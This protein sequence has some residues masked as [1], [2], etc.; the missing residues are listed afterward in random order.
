MINPDMLPLLMF[1]ALAVLLFSG[2]P[3]AFILAGTAFIFGLIGWAFDY[4]SLIQFYNI[5][6][7]IYGAI[8]ANLILVAIPMF[9]F[10]GIMLEK[11][12]V[13]EDLLHTMQVLLRRVPGGLAMAVTA[14]GTILAATTGI[15]GASVIMMALL[16]LP[17]MLQR[18][19]DVRLATGTVAASG[20]LGILIPPSIMLI[21]L[22]NL[23]ATPVGTLFAAALIPGLLL[24]SFYLAYIY[25]ACRITP[26]L[27]PSLGEEAAPTSGRELTILLLRSFI[28]PTFLIFMVLGSILFGWAT[29]TEASGTGALGAIL[30]AVFNRRLSWPVLKE[31]LH[32]AAETNVMIFGIF[33]GATAFA[34][35][36]RALG[37]DFIVTDLFE[38]LN[39]GP[40]GV[41]LIMMVVIFLLGF[42]LDWIEII[43][44]V[45][46]IFTPIVV[47]LDFGGHVQASQI[48]PWFAILIAVN[49]QTSYLT[50]PFGY[51]L[52]YMKGAS[53]S[54]VRMQ[55]IYRGIIPFVVLQ[56]LAVLAVAFFPAVALWLPG[57]L[58]H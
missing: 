29:P 45:L 38:S 9:I 18:G 11:S 27:A 8:G 5:A 50:P 14:M 16:A 7:R 17:V 6:T 58:L 46:P 31:V 43:L 22:A 48:L 24:A 35:V 33:I 37:G 56:L 25:T 19:Y 52:F 49:L 12:G 42:L 57:V 54:S 53:P 32:R 2:F 23:M 10:M 3:V 20:T 40:W 41:L 34:Y 44:I 4:F 26:T 15:V 21:I 55:Q 39:T 30:L 28:P 36:F 47:A 13:A 51:A 1:A